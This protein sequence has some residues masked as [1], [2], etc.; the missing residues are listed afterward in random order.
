MV[1]MIEYTDTARNQL[2]RLDKQSAKR[3][4]DFMDERVS[5]REDPRTTGKALTGPLGGLWR[6]RVGDFRVICEIQD[7]ALRIL[8]VQLGNRSDIYR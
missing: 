2:R 5:N 6:Y 3:I 1:W 8:V 4:L 7:G